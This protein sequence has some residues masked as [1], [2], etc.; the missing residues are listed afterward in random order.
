VVLASG[1]HAWKKS[2][3]GI[4][5][6]THGKE[7]VRN[8]GELSWKREE[9]GLGQAGVCCLHVAGRAH[10]TREFPYTLQ[11]KDFQQ[12]KPKSLGE[13]FRKAP[14]LPPGEERGNQVLKEERGESRSRSHPG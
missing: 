1:I 13:F 9:R 12:V 2:K 10:A 3:D 4:E 6:K 8:L 11:F 14:K 7:G 5:N